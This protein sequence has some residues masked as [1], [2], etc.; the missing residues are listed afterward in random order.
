MSISGINSSNAAYQ[1]TLQSPFQQ[2][3]ADFQQLG[4]SLSTGNLSGAQQAFSAL[5]SLIQFQ[6][7]SAANTNGSSG[8]GS[9]LSGGNGSPLAADLTQIGQALQGGNL[10]AAQQGFANLMQHLHGHGHHHHGGNVQGGQNVQ[11]VP[12]ASS[13]DGDGDG[14]GTINVT[15]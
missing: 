12:A 15:A 13:S 4:Q 2:G 3:T 9:P 6:G 1:N 8:N 14:S 5:M 11:A 10:S 7:S